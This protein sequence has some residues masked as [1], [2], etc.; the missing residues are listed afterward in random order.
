MNILNILSSSAGIW[1]DETFR[2]FDHAILQAFRDLHESAGVFF[3]PFF[4]F[5]TYLGDEGIAIIIFALMLVCFNK[6][7]RAGVSAGV[8]IL[9]GIIIT[10]LILKNVV[11]RAR[12]YNSSDEYYRWFVEVFNS[13][14]SDKSFPSG[15][16]T[17]AFAL[18]TALFLVGDKRYSWLGF[19][20]G[21]LMCISR[22]YLVVHYPTDVIAGAL[23]GIISGIGGYFIT[24]AIYKKINKH[25]NRFTNVF[26]TYDA[27]SVINS[28]KA[29]YNKKKQV[30]V[31]PPILG[32]D[33][34]SD[35]NLSG[36]TDANEESA[37]ELNNS[38]DLVNDVNVESSVKSDANQAVDVLNNKE[39]K[40]K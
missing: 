31:A 29:K 36:E 21:S 11:D 27:F 2:A 5:I 18:V 23:V 25:D 17:A 33:C 3:D 24:S 37:N 20:F 4:K 14:L 26:L 13:G 28:I 19:I 10:N 7:R 6:T 38:L 40:K 35:D 39:D 34:G 15:H 30:A 22:I 9:I 1:L 16:A 8:A 12:P 32:C